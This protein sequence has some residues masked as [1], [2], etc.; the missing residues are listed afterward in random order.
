MT[1]HDHIVLGLGGMGSAAAYHLAAR[2][3][4]VL[5]LEKFSPPHDRGSSHGETRVVR[6][7]YFEHPGYVPLLRRA[8]EL[9]RE[10]ETSTNTRLLHLCGGLMMGSPDSAVVAGSLRSAQEHRL[11]HEMLDAAEIRRR[12]PSF[13]LDGDAVGLFEETAG[14]VRCEDAVQAHLDAAA[15]AG[16]ELR[17]HEP[18]LS[19]QAE[20]D[21]VRVTTEQGTYTAAR[22]IITPGA[23]APSLL[24]DLGIPIS[25]ER[26]VLYWFQPKNGVTAYQPDK[27]PVYIR[28]ERP[29]V[30]AYGFP[31]LNGPDGGMKV[32]FFHQP[33]REVTTPESVDRRI[34]EDDIA[35]MRRAVRAF[36]PDLD[37]TFLRGVTCFYSMT[38]DQHF[39][40][41]HHR[42]HANVVLAAGFSGHGFKFCPVIGE[43]LAG[44]ACDG[45]TR[46]DISL[47]AADRFKASARINPKTRTVDL[48]R[49]REEF[50]PC[51]GQRDP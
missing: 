13:Q 5:G 34:R 6:Q 17:Y 28:Q 9:W 20:K 33:V 14:Y 7:A 49:C 24:T 35:A 44:L 46:H 10:L 15:R 22:L 42:R 3:H 23:W 21:H 30:E 32:A 4:R 26:Q 41:G 25:V 1:S 48:G 19:W 2:G 40:I 18:V 45:S 36:F 11:P 16:A 47:F 39:A 43:I 51:A 12:Y 50:G 8:Y 29:G 31:A 27:F 38:P 37:G